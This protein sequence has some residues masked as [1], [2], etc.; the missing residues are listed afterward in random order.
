MIRIIKIVLFNYILSFFLVTVLYFGLMNL[1]IIYMGSEILFFRGIELLVVSGV[2]SLWLLLQIKK[3]ITTNYFSLERLVAGVVIAV[4]INLV[5]LVIFPVTFER[6]VSMYLLE[7]L[8]TAGDSG[9]VISQ[10]TEKMEKEYVEKNGAINKR[11]EEQSETG[12][13]DVGGKVIKLTNN[14]KKFLLFSETVGR[15]YGLDKK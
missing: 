5:C 3:I 4:S 12:F 2:I 11:I 7:Q 10:L 6:S 9:L 15:M 1:P 8:N 14:G 13:V